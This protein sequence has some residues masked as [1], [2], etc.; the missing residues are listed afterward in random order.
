V[1]LGEIGAPERGERVAVKVWNRSFSGIPAF[2]DRAL[3]HGRALARIRHPGLIHVRASGVSGAGRVVWE[4]HAF[5]QPLPP[6]HWRARRLPQELERITLRALSKRPGDRFPSAAAFAAELARC[7][8]Q[9][10]ARTTAFREP[11][12][13]L[14]ES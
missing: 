14:L 10:E 9:P 4:A 6:S 2:V 12:L 13:A 5:E 1:F 11:A 8:V 7:P 3:D